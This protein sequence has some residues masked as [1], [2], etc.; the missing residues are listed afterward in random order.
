[1]SVFLCVD[2]VGRRIRADFVLA[3]VGALVLL[4]GSAAVDHVF[5]A[6]AAAFTVILTAV[7][8]CLC[9]RLTL[10]AWLMISADCCS[11]LG[12]IGAVRCCIL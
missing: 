10:V 5:C 7:R 8:C 6:G 9:L 1:M 3:F 12:T 11:N 2:T 4:S